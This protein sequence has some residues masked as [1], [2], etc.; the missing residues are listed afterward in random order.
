M[1]SDY[2]LKPLLEKLQQIVDQALVREV[3]SAISVG[4]KAPGFGI[5][6]VF[7]GEIAKVPRIQ[8]DEETLYDLAS[9]TKII[10]TTLAVALAVAEGRLLLS[11]RPFSFWPEITVENLLA[12]RSGLVAHRHFYMD[13]HLRGATSFAAKKEILLEQLWK[14]VPNQ[15]GRVYSD[16]GFIALGYWLEKI[17]QMPLAQVFARAW[18]EAGLGDQFCYFDSVKDAQKVGHLHVAPTGFCAYRNVDLRAQVHDLNCFVMGGLAGHAG[19]FSKLSSVMNFGE[20]IL[21]SLKSPA[22]PLE[23]ELQ[24]FSR[25]RLGFDIPTS[26][27]SNRFLSG[28]SV[29]HFG[30]TGTALWVDKA[31]N[32]QR[33]VVIALLSNRVHKSIEP[34]GIFWLRSK[35]TDET[36]KF[37]NSVT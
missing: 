5:L 4:I 26:A 23:Y 15:R 3:A 28:S 11:D 18:A 24:R 2:S 9:L 32:S 31:A 30:Y 6:K 10:G 17:Y 21:K 34:S 7:G 16:S 19:L 12:H 36:I 25:R 8:V 33:G 29:G 35:V 37:F 27:G 20:F 22:S 13:D 1:N 14:E